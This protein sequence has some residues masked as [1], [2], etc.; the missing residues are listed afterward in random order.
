MSE[1]VKQNRRKLDKKTVVGVVCL[2]ICLFSVCMYRFFIMRDYASVYTDENQAL[3]WYGTVAASN[4]QLNEPHFLGQDYGSM[5]ESIVAVPFYKLGVP[6]NV[7]L[8]LATFILFILPFVIL[9]VISLVKGNS[10]LS[11]SLMGISLIF[12]WNIDILASIPRSFLSGFAI[13]F[14]AYVLFR[15]NSRL[16]AI[17]SPILFAIAFINTESTITIIALSILE[18]VLYRFKDT[19]RK[20]PFYLAGTAIGA[21]LVVYCNNI[22]YKL[23]PECI[24]FRFPKV[25]FP[26]LKCFK[27]NINNIPKLLKSFSAYNF[28]GI[29]VALLLIAVIIVAFLLVEKRYKGLITLFC[30]FLGSTAVLSLARTFNFVGDLLFS[31][32]RM[33]LF[34]PYVI[35]FCAFSIFG[36]KDSGNVNKFSLK[37]RENGI[38]TTAVLSVAVLGLAI[39]KSYYF[40][41]TVLTFDCLY[42]DPL[43]HVEKVEDVNSLSNVIREQSLANDV[44]TII[45]LSDNRCAVYTLS[46]LNPD[47]V[48]YNS[49]MDRRTYVFNY[50][51]ENVYS[52]DVLTLNGS[53]MGP[54]ETNVEHIENRTIIEWLLTDYGRQRYPDDSPFHIGN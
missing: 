20:W 21:G 23:H 25:G 7:C 42:T 29:P 35:L 2:L 52:Q 26:T 49:I 51:D 40:E 11:V 50:L 38:W 37:F 47:M 13:A 6:L 8:P 34:F 32:E 44:D 12:G 4:F 17:I 1:I 53:G 46:A 30:A 24:V 28:N 19:I 14:I 39:G 16:T 45:F 15:R 22:F 31:Q 43:I 5:L 27:D 18:F 3:M 48:I 33:F 10:F 41:K 36:N 9:S 54:Y